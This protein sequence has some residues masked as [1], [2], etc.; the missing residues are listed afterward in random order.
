MSGSA[1]IN[2]TQ[3]SRNMNETRS[4]P[5]VVYRPDGPHLPE[6]R[7]HR[8]SQTALLEASGR[9]FD[10]QEPGLPVRRPQGEDTEDRGPRIVVCRGSGDRVRGWGVRRPD[11]ERRAAGRAPEPRDPSHLHLLRPAG[12]QRRLPARDRDDLPG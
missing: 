2:E 1:L 12:R 9:Y 10:D 6:T 7:E 4:R 5:S 11:P 8:L 3:L